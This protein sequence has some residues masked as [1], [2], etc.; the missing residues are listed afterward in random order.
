MTTEVLGSLSFLDNP[1]GAGGQLVVLGTGV[2]SLVSDITANRPTAGTA[3][4]VF[5]DSSTLR[6]QLDNG[7]TW[8][9]LADFITYTGTA[10]QIAVSGSVLG[11]SDDPILPGTGRMRL[12]VGTTAQRPGVPSAGDVRFN[13]TLGSVE[14]YNGTYWSVFGLVL[15]LVTG[16][17]A[18]SSGV[19]NNIPLDNT[20]PLSTEGN[21]IW[22]QSFTPISAT[23]RIIIE[24]GIV[25]ASSATTVSN[26]LSVFAGTTNIGSTMQRVPA[27]TGAPTNMTMQIVHQPG[28]TATIT[29]SA[30]HG[31]SANSTAFC[32]QSSGATL[33]GAAASQFTITEIE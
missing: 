32:N 23:S 8:D 4:R 24:F 20:T 30:R 21:Q 15:Q 3:G 22:T 29:Y 26:I 2:P 33:G 31:G 6:I 16:T 25:S 14:R 27:T 28:S 10:N 18:A 19:N 13:S 11:L 12:P 17:I 1:I 9:T 7:S 5:F